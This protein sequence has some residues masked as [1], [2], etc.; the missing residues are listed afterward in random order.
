[1]E[2][3]NPW[4]SAKIGCHLRIPIPEPIH[5]SKAVSCTFKAFCFSLPIA[6]TGH[7]E[8]ILKMSSVAS[9]SVKAE[10][11]SQTDGSPSNSQSSVNGF[12]PKFLVIPDM[13]V[14]FLAE[15]GRVN[16]HYKDVRAESIVWL[17]EWVGG[18]NGSLYYLTSELLFRI[19]GFDAKR[20]ETYVKADFAHIAAGFGPE[21]DSEGC[22]TYCDWMN[23]VCAILTVDARLT[24][25]R[26]SSLT[27][28]RMT[29]VRYC[30]A[31]GS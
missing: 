14:S 15:K 23:W 24:K 9:L 5:L 3:E 8:N 13:F 11:S 6:N 19:C 29:L 2:D 21:A 4:K 7:F 22:R 12:C 30:A 18:L 28:V 26:S 27:I 25:S 20:I 31:V 17:A 16:I 10:S 1:M